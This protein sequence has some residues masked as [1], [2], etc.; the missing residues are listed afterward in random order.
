VVSGPA[1]LNGALLNLL[2]A[3]TVVV[4][5]SQPGD[6]RYLAVSESKTIVVSGGLA[7]VISVERP[8]DRSYAPGL[9]I[10]LTASAN[11]GLPVTLTLNE[12][13][14]ELTA[15]GLSVQG[16]GSFRITV[17]QAGDATYSAADPVSVTFV[18]TKASQKLSVADVGSRAFGSDPIPLQGSSSS[19]LPVSFSVVEGAASI[20]NGALKLTGIGVVKL[21]ADQSGNANYEAA[22]RVLQTVE[23]LPAL[24]VTPAPTGTPGPATLEVF[25]PSGVTGEVEQCDVLGNWTSIGSV[26]GGGP[27]TPAT[28]LVI[29]PGGQAS[30]RFWRIRVGP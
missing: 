11:S 10:P 16:A 30:S 12:G 13:P 24:T 5:A 23:V 6:D 20:E 21:A 9:V 25:L 4:S 7:Q 8:S 19:G 22:P 1:V 15:A 28:L 29:P 2:T 3:G 14:G 18:I 27:G 26:K 17:T